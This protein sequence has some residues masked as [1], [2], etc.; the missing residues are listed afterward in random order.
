M[1]TIK[2][3]FPKEDGVLLLEEKGLFFMNLGG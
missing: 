2:P 3:H 1:N